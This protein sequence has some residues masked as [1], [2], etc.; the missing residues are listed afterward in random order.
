MI[1][2]GYGIAAIVLFCLL[3]F[4]LFAL[5]FQGGND[6]TRRVARIGI[7]LA[8]AIVLGIAESF[9][10]DF[11]LPG[12][13]IGLANVAVIIVLY[14]FGY[15]EGLAVGLGKAIT[16][17][18]LR[19]TLFAMGGWMALVGTLFSFAVMALLK[20]TFPR[21]SVI[22]ISTFGSLAHVSGQML[23]AW[24]YL[25]KAVWGYMPYLALMAFLTG[26]LVGVLSRIILK[27]KKAMAF[28]KAQ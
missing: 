11:L 9:I 24:A 27:R 3:L 19:G 17:S 13:R 23:V 4:P 21:L 5:L 25:G 1:L 18:L 20:A 22:A 15:N 16:V 26:I 14:A 7:M 10:P 6:S 12:M 2:D 28:L 8:L